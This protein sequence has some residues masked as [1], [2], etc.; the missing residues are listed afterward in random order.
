MSANS[1]I[2]WTHHTFNPWW[3]CV[4]VSPGC[5]NCY[6]ETWAKRTG[7]DVWGPAKT[8]PRREMSDG[9]WQKPL[10]WNRKAEE[11]GERA[12]VFCA[13]MADV[14]EDH[15]QLPALRARLWLL[16]E[17][18][19]WLDWQLLTKRPENILRMAPEHWGDGFPPN[20]WVG[21]S[22]EDQRRWDERV[23]VLV[24][25]PASVLFLSMEPLVGPVRCSGELELIEWVIIGGESGAKARP[26]DVQWVRDILAACREVGTAPFVKQLGASWHE[27][28]ALVRP[29]RDAKGGDPAEWPADL[30]VREFPQIGALS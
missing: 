22:V 8:T 18:T 23:P 9:H 2:E 10:A 19:P 26:L 24:R 3:G 5:E 14:F 17:A 27:Q 11:A 29:V 1:K 6:A 15:P 16:I 13:S 7:H 28:L 20:V 12:R 25:V 30:R 21:T 4:R